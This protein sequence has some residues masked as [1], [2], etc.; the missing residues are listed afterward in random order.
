M[1]TPKRRS[2]SLPFHPNNRTVDQ[3]HYKIKQ[4]TTNLNT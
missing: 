1:I 3:I 2:E 4:P